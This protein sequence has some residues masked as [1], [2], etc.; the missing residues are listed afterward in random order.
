M[1]ESQESPPLG[2]DR[3]AAGVMQVKADLTNG[4]SE[5]LG[6]GPSMAN[7]R[8]YLVFL[9]A[10]ILVSLG[11]LS[12]LGDIY[13][14]P[15]LKPYYA[16]ISDKEKL[17]GILKAAG[18]WA[19]VVYILIEVAQV[20][21]MFWPV[22]W[23]IAGG[24]LFGLPWGMFY[25][26]VGLTTGAVLAFLLG[27]WLEKTYLRRFI[28]PQDLRR[29]RKLM[30]REGALTAFIIFLVPGVPKDF[31]S[32]VLGFT[33]L[34]LKFFVVAAALFRL[35]STFLL[36]LEG[37]EAAKGNYW[38]SVGLLGCNYLLAVLIYRYRE[39]LYQWIKA[40]HVEDL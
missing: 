27:R 35:P 32:Y 24:Y 14:W 20:L 36:S 28:D 3:V 40:W 25:S 15:L 8:E 21:T 9:A 5:F 13:L 33:T 6:V 31:V 4:I 2:A 38:L 11:I 19:P 1:A 39:Y 23:E 30:R 22:P 37:A 7:R 26:M 29:F 17:S 12:W 18:N 34:S 16:I 10:S